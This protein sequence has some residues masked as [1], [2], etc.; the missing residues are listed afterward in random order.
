M[1]TYNPASIRAALKTLLQTASG[2][3]AVYDFMNPNIEG[4]PA[5]IF[6]LDNEDASMLDDA[7]NLRV[8]TFKIWIVVEIPVNGQQAAKDSLDAQTQAVINI[9]ELKANDTLSGT[10]DWIIPVVGKRDQV[11]SPE[12][13]LMY[14]E[15]NLK[16][17]IA[18]TIL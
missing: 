4:Y 3:A 13:N 14:Q 17:N 15:L 9:L 10:V 1:A 12:G 8:I 5:V 7:N 18:S 11:Q 2:V 6:D 16:C